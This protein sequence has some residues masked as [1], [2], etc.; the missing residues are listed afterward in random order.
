MKT[1]S[2]DHAG[3]EV[4]VAMLASMEP[5]HEGREH[6]HAIRRVNG[7][8][9]LI[10]QWNPAIETRNTSLDLARVIQLAEAS[11]E[12]G[13]E[14]R[15]YRSQ[16]LLLLTCRNKDICER[17]LGWSAQSTIHSYV[18]FS[19]NAPTSARALPGVCLTDSALAS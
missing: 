4:G 5:G 10:P 15:E 13:R 3:V 11:M 14:D 19:K 6:W 12:P 2:T 7:A 9:S 8:E 18:E 16:N 17:R 1:G